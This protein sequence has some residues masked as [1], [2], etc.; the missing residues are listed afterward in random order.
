M[1]VNQVLCDAVHEKG[2]IRL[3]GPVKPFK[4]I[5][6]DPQGFVPYSVRPVCPGSAKVVATADCK[7]GLSMPSYK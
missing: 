5:N 4:R 1:R 3:T 7:F 6:T 2:L